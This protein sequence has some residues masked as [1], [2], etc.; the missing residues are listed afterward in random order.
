MKRVLSFS[1]VA[2]GLM[3]AGQSFAQ[4]S[5]SANAN[6]NATIIKGISCSKT[7]DLEFGAIVASVAGGSVV[8]PPD[9]SAASYTGVSAY[10]G[11]AAPQPAQF[12][13][14]GEAGKSYSVTL[15]NFISITNAN[16]ASMTVDGFASHSAANNI[17]LANGTDILKVG[18]KL[19]VAANQA[20]GLYSGS[21]SVTV[22]YQ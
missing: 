10:P 4:T 22:A 2:A 1:L 19:Q 18:A 15:P 14:T 8:V 13:V 20:A 21:F 7:Q 16:N 17:L 3:L 9:G 5:A 11:S 6:A 12:D